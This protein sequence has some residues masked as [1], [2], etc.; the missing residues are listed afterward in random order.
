MKHRI[1]SL[2]TRNFTF[3]GLVIAFVLVA[4]IT[5]LGFADTAPENTSADKS[6][7]MV[8]SYYF[9]NYH[10]NDALNRRL[11]IKEEGWSEWELVKKATPRFPG[12]HQPHVPLWGYEDESSPQAMA[13]KID[14]AADHG[15]G[16]FI[17]DWYWYKN[18]PYLERPLDEGFLKASNVER[19]K[20]SLM[21]A[22]HDWLELQPYTRGKPP[23]LIFPGKVTQETFDTLAQH[24]IDKYFKH[25]SYWKI[26][27][28]PYFS[29]YHL[30]TLLEGFG[31]VQKTRE[32]LD[33]FR[34]RCRKAGLP[35]LHL[36]LIVWGQPVLPGEGTRADHATLVQQLGFDSV[37][38]YVWAHHVP[39]PKMQTDYEYVQEKYLEFW[40]K[41]REQFEVPYYPNVTMGWDPSPRTDQSQEYGN[42]G[43]PF[44]NTI[45]GNTPARFEK[46][47]RAV[48]E[49]LDK[50]GGPRILNI[51]CWNEWT[52]GSYLEP[53]MVHGMQYLEAVKRVFVE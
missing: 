4:G 19:L 31:S 2:A 10:P 23:E 36:N 38:S 52:E 20:F 35:G 9:P 29:I 6:D 46:A 5:H 22:N 51:N 44:T 16:A 33:S 49:R 45:S 17:F 15:I 24:C 8:A 3:P 26:D 34:L 40:D 12:H 28:K 30:S 7:Y 47:L 25:P 41:A 50:S 43:Y 42:F 48:K 18:G 13:R 39:F 21:W 37:T 27:G 32:A 11:D 14:A 1:R 53:D